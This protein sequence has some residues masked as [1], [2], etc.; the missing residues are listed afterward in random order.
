MAAVGRVQVDAGEIAQWQ[1]PVAAEAG[2]GGAVGSGT[3]GAHAVSRRLLAVVAPGVP[4]VA[5][6]TPAGVIETGP[7]TR[8][9]PARRWWPWAAGAAAVVV[10]GVVTTVLI[11][12]G[13]DTPGGMFPTV[14]W[15]TRDF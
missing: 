14:D 12:S 15:R 7:E 8:T 11:T 1:V 10:A 4:A 3:G 13:G 9:T 2:C 5:A 6:G